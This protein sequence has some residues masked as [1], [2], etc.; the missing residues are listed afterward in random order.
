MPTPHVLPHKVFQMI[1]VVPRWEN[2]NRK[3]WIILC[4]AQTM[5]E[6]V[7]VWMCVTVKWA[8]LRQDDSTRSRFSYRWVRMAPSSHT[9]IDQFNQGSE[10]FSFVCS[11]ENSRHET[12]V[13]C[14]HVQCLHF[15]SFAIFK[16]KTSI[17]HSCSSQT[18]LSKFSLCQPRIVPAASGFQREIQ[19]C[20][21]Q[22][23][24]TNWIPIN[25]LHL[26]LALFS[27]LYQFEWC[28]LCT[29]STTTC[30]NLLHHTL[31]AGPWPMR[32]IPFCLVFLPFALLGIRFGK[33][34]A[35]GE[36]TRPRILND[37]RDM[38]WMLANEFYIQIP[39]NGTFAH[40]ISNRFANVHNLFR[41]SRFRFCT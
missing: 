19:I 25:S 20:I 22:K 10:K 1:L 15:S 4:E 41:G 23:M 35:V 26:H 17:F 12:W 31:R 18:N 38:W 37:D 27:H 32:T 30:T 21:K 34:Q 7:A 3:T 16:N 5:N 29:P 2:M 39:S 33:V 24:E 40:N 28:L 6:C 11:V 9:P 36:R 13:L 14:L 8:R